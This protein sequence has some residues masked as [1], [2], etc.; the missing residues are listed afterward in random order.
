MRIVYVLTSLGMGGAERQVLALA[1]RMAERGHAVA[2]MVLRP[3]VSEEWPTALDVIHLDMR[4]NPVSVIAGM[5]RGRRFMKGFR[6]ELIH[7]H[8]FH[9]NFVARLLGFST[10]AMVISTVH[11]VYEGGWHRMFL[12]RLTDFLSVR[13]TAVSTAAA[14]RFV[15]LKA[16][17]KRKCVV[18]T[19]GIDTAEFAPDTERRLHMRTAMSAGEN[20]IWLTAGRIAPAKDIPNLLGA[21]ALV[22]AAHPTAKLW[23]AGEGEPI[24]AQENVIW[25]GLR[26]DLPALLEAADGFVLASAWEGMPLVVGEAMAMEKPVVATDVGGVR[27]LTGDAATLVPAKDSHALAEAMIT[28]MQTPLA[29][30][31]NLGRAARSRIVTG[32]SIDARVDRW[33]QLYQSL[34]ARDC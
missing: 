23:I 14:E 15:R 34:L 26:R 33:E 7:S 21:F 8:S 16:V 20:F 2:I 13:T 19:N 30:R 9:A 5:M 18:I 6:P 3:Q 12:Y 4:R 10:Q 24:A 1:A 31:Q 27:E 29:D 28:S 22:R 32:F 17:P 25:V 11:N